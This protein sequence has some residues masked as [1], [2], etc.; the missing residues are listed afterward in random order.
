MRR[1]AIGLA[2]TMSMG[3][4]SGQ[5]GSWTAWSSSG[6]DMHRIVAH[7]NPEPMPK[8]DDPLDQLEAQIEAKHAEIS[9]LMHERNAR[10]Q[11]DQLR[12]SLARAFDDLEKLEAERVALLAPRIGVRIPTL[13]DEDLAVI[14]EARKIRDK[15]ENPSP[16]NTAAAEHTRTR[17]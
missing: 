12:R 9:R 15:Y 10:P 8:P 6:I 3:T 13:S 4:R 2:L 1:A 11:D 16:D 17:A 7:G 14:N 5:T